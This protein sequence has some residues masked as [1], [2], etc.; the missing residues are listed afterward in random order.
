MWKHVCFCLL[1]VE[2]VRD[3]YVIGFMVTGFLLFGAGGFLVYY[4]FCELSVVIGK[5]PDLHTV[6]FYLNS[7]T[8][9]F[10]LTHFH[11]YH[12][13]YPIEGSV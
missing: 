8:S 1:S 10:L 12:L 3:N 9:T 13:T 5:L 4:K 2:D 7:R 6:S 11:G